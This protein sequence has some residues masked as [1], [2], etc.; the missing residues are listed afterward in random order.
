V[1]SLIDR[2]RDRED[3]LKIPIE[4]KLIAIYFV[5]GSA[6]SFGVGWLFFKNII[7]GAGFCVS[8]FLLFPVFTEF[9][10]NI[11]REEMNMQ[12]K[13]VLYA[14]SDAAASGKSAQLSVDNAYR[15]LRRIYGDNNVLTESFGEMTLKIKE[16][17]AAPEKV[18]MDFALKCEIEDIRNFIEIYCICLTSGGDREKAIA[19][20]ASIIGEKINL[21]LELRNIL[22][23]KKLE[24][25]ILCC[26]TPIIL[27]FL[28]ITS[29]EYTAVLYSTFA[30]RII[31]VGCLAAAV[32]AAS[33]CLKIMDIRI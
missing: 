31:M 13:D 27:L 18:L 30:G 32:F 10:R 5:V 2:F 28:Q 24:A 33:K 23:Q 26:I 6:A 29:A 15:N 19:K 14:F 20:A 16:T 9:V 8:P 12:F 11:K 21:R 25:A 4:K 7:V 17:N 3:E 22:A 1:Y